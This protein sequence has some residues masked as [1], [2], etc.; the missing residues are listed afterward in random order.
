MQGRLSRTAPF[1]FLDLEIGEVVV[2]EIRGRRLGPALGGWRS[3]SGTWLLAVLL[4]LEIGEVVV[5]GRRLL[6]RRRLW[7]APA[8]MVGWGS[9]RRGT[10]PR[11][12]NGPL[13]S[14]SGTPPAG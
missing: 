1:F 5:I 9:L 3:P 14:G 2:I 7:L 6:I 10:A 12:G 13:R 8:H 4:D 11:Q